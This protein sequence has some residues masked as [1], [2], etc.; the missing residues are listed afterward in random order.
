MEKKNVIKTAV[1]EKVTLNG[2]RPF[3][4]TSIYHGEFASGKPYQIP[5]S[6]WTSQIEFTDYVYYPDQGMITREGR[7]AGSMVGAGANKLEVVFVHTY[8]FPGQE[9]PRLIWYSHK[10]PKYGVYRYGFLVL[11]TRDRI[12]D[13]MEWDFLGRD[14]AAEL[15]NFEQVEAF[16]NHTVKVVPYARLLFAARPGL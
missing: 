9:D 6:D 7:V 2:G 15:A 12:L 4:M 16:L 8:D 10:L 1:M 11:D 5:P 14:P 13:A 3:N